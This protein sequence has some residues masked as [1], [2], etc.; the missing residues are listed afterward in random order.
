MKPLRPLL[1]AA[2]A[3]TA[4]AQTTP[5]TKPAAPG[6]PA[7]ATA[8]AKPFSPGDTHIYIT[9]TEAMEFQLKVSEKLNWKMKDGDPEIVA[10]AGKITKEMTDLYTPGVSLAQERG[11]PG[12]A[13]KK[14]K[15][16]IIP[17]DMSQNN[18]AALAK[19]DAMNKDEKKWVVALFEL[20]AK[21][22]KKG[23]AEAEKGAKAAQ[24]ADLKAYAEKAAAL[25]KSESEAVEAKF[26]QL[27]TAKK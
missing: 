3:L 9:V 13:D 12:G 21:E 25:L 19:V 26:K 27:K 5:G 15:T 18:K 20:F 23:A 16:G 6:P 24:D 11:V 10:I 2:L 22:S 4:T 1:F 14:S 8:K 7:A 17:N